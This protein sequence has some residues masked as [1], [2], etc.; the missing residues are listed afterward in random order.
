MINYNDRKKQPIGI[1]SHESIE[2]P[3]LDAHHS[4]PS[5]NHSIDRMTNRR[6]LHKPIDGFHPEDIQKFVRCIREKE[7][8]YNSK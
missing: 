8:D 2:Y 5:R 6:D 1:I 3:H 4:H 7:R